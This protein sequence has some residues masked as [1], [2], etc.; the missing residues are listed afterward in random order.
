MKASARFS[1]PFIVTNVGF[2]IEPYTTK[3]S[4]EIVE[5]DFPIEDLEQA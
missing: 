4:I 3:Q 5:R 1:V 2:G